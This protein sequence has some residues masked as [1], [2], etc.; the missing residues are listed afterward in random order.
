MLKH[1]LYNQSKSYNH[2]SNNYRIACIKNA[3]S[4]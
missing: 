2:H 3:N 4:N 1:Y